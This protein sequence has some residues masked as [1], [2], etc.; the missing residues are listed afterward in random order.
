VGRKLSS[1][2]RTVTLS[3]DGD[4]PWR[5]SIKFSFSISAKTG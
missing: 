1:A 4:S 5:L 3:P 2:F